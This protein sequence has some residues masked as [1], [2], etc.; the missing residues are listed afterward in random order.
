[1]VLA[2][3]VV[4]HGDALSSVEAPGPELPAEAATKMPADAAPRN[5]TSVA[6][7]V[8]CAAPPP[9]E[10]LITS[11][12]SAVAWSIAA[13]RSLVAHP[14]SSWLA[15]S[16]PDQQTLYAAIFAAGAT[17]EMVPKS[18]PPTEADTAWLPTAVLPVCEP[19][20]SPSRGETYSPTSAPPI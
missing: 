16:G 19:W 5:A 4:I 18:I 11:T 9:M 8:V 2:A 17:P 13:T 10:K 12:P 6:E 15:G 7:T 20:P 1:M 14:S 3:T